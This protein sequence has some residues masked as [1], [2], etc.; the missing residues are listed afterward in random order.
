M[1]DNAMA[2]MGLCTRAFDRVLKV[3][4]TIADLEGAEVIDTPMYLKLF[5]TATWTVLSEGLS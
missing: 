3:V 1:L 2:K 5:S 4:R